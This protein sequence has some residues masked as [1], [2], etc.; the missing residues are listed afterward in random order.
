MDGFLL[1]FIFE[2]FRK[3]VEKLKFNYSLTRITGAL[4]EDPCTYISPWMLLIMG[5]VS[6]KS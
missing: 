6:D 5:T 3:S 1:K 4:H 2:N